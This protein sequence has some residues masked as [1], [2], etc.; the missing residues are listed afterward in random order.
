MLNAVRSFF[1]SR[2]YLEIESPILT[3]YPSLD[4][5]ILAFE[6]TFK[7]EIHDSRSFYLHTSPEHAMKKCLAEGIDRIFY[8]GKVFRNGELTPMHNPEFTMV[9]W[10]RTGI[11]YHDI[12]KETEALILHVLKAVQTEQKLEYQGHSIELTQPWE[13]ITV[14]DC[15]IEK[16]G[17]DLEN[18]R[19]P[20]L[21]RDAATH[22]GIRVRPDD[23]WETVFYKLFL[24]RIEPGLG[25]DKPVFMMDYPIKMALMARRKMENPLWVER[26]ELYIAGIELANGYSELTDPV[27]Q[28]DRF[29]H[30]QDHRKKIENR[31]YPIDTELVSALE[32]GIKPCAGMALGFDRLVMLCLDKTRVE[33]TLLFPFTPWI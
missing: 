18:T 15:F 21:L 3:P 16:T 11:D 23:D 13:K 9:E 31:T 22:I 17:I 26:C 27:E 6:T 29:K 25:I 32:S 1:E 7:S 4:S 14:R 20:A 5:N 10:Y 33:E 12:M 2:Q 28:M 8:A 24:E 19:T 30:A